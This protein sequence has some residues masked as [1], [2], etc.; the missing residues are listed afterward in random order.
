M[1]MYAL[2]WLKR[3][4]L[5]FSAVA[6]TLI[7]AFIASRLDIV[8]ALRSAN[9]SY[10][11]PT[12]EAVIGKYG[13]L[14]GHF[15]VI[16]TAVMVLGIFGLAWLNRRYKPSLVVWAQ[17]KNEFFFRCDDWLV[18]KS[19]RLARSLGVN[20][21]L[22]YCGL[23]LSSVV[24]IAWLIRGLSLTQTLGGI[25]YGLV[26]GA[27]VAS[28]VVLWALVGLRPSLKLLVASLLVS[29]LVKLM[30]AAV[31]YGNT[32]MIYWEQHVRLLKEGGSLYVSGRAIYPYTPLWAWIIFG[33][34]HIAVLFH[35]SFFFAERVLI[36]V[37]D[38][39]MATLLYTILKRRAGG[40]RAAL[41]NTAYFAL[42][43]VSVLISGYHG[44]FDNIVFSFV[45][46]IILLESRRVM[47]PWLN[48]VLLGL[49]NALKQVIAV[50][51][52]FFF[53]AAKNLK[54]R[55][56]L[57]V[58]V[59]AAFIAPFVYDLLRTPRQVLDNIT[60][61]NSWY[62]YG[63]VRLITDLLKLVGLSTEAVFV[64]AVFL[65][66]GKY[67]LFGALALYLARR[68]RR[69]T[70]T[71]GIT[72]SILFFYAFTPAFAWQYLMWIIPF[73]FLE[74]DRWLKYFIA[75]GAGYLFFAYYGAESHIAW[76]AA[77]SHNVLAYVLWFVVLCWFLSRHIALRPSAEAAGLHIV[78]DENA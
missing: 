6:A 3:R 5:L 7:T 36:I 42:N 4:P 20:P 46:L 25:F 71:Q 14:L 45:L 18:N 41:T 49:A 26:L 8:T 11:S 10:H 30:I 1:T 78:S 15:F 67:L 70:T 75:V 61:Y 37:A 48:Y 31:F 64:G 16:G 69:L 53:F 22:W 47:S 65:E 60:A 55:L 56:L 38:V 28:A 73:A 51:L 76:I 19:Q 62:N 74:H 68:A 58:T 17:K 72:I 13:S 63:Y 50:V 33:V 57:V 2:R 34:D 12:I 29:V 24:V 32:D 27:L 77:V 66:L 21:V 23:W 35:L 44:Q 43:P 9:I 39:V 59:V 52:P 40:E 54:Q